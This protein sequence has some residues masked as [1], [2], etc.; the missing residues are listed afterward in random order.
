MIGGSTAIA[1]TTAPATSAV[2]PLQPETD[3]AALLLDESAGQMIGVRDATS[4][5]AVAVQTEEI[6]GVPLP[7]SEREIETAVMQEPATGAD[8]SPPLLP[9]IATLSALALTVAPPVSQTPVALADPAI[10]AAP[11]PDGPSEEHQVPAPVAAQYPSETPEI[12]SP[13]IEASSEFRVS[14]ARAP[15]PDTAPRIQVAASDTPSISI[16]QPLLVPDRAVPVVQTR[17]DLR[18]FDLATR[19]DGGAEWIDRITR[20]IA[21]SQGNSGELRFRVVPGELGQITVAMALVESGTRLRIEVPTDQARTVV[22]EA[23]PQVSSTAY[24][25][26]APISGSSVEL[27]QRPPGRGNPEGRGRRRFEASEDGTPV[28]VS[29]A[30]DRHRYA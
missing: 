10:H 21:A 16:P 3:F 12:R 9:D 15:Q 8:I 24:L 22:E 7:A 17:A 28:P 29:S 20:D 30:T 23:R 1:A 18:L 25:L 13:Q 2:V 27:G 4:A 6:I 26:G 11:H 14:E 5:E 19:T